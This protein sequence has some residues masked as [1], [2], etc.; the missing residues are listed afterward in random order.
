MSSFAE[1][2]LPLSYTIFEEGGNCYA[3]NGKTRAIDFRGTDAVTV[4]NSALNALTDGRTWQE[5]VTLRGNF[6]LTSPIR[7]PEYTVLDL[8]AAKL[9]LANAANCNMIQNPD[10]SVSADERTI[11]GG[12]L[13]GNKANQT[14]GHGVHLFGERIQILNMQ[15]W[16][17][18]DYAVSIHGYGTTY[19]RRIWVLDN[20]LINNEKG[21]IN[22]DYLTGAAWVER[23][24]CF[25][26]GA[27]KAT[28]FFFDF[29]GGFRICCIN[30]YLLSGARSGLR[31]RAIESVI[32]YN[33]IKN[34]DQ[35]GIIM[36]DAAKSWCIGN[37]IMDIALTGTSL[38]DG[39]YIWGTT[40]N[41]HFLY[42]TIETTGSIKYA[43]NESE[44]DWNDISHN[45]CKTGT[46]NK[47]GLN[48]I[49][50]DNLVG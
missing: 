39:I 17:C 31:C 32:A 26:Q 27:A 40:N 19:S 30:N 23:N 50:V 12:I 38:Y 29:E 36:G 4:I 7:L 48:S 10:A 34:F 33:R 13:D 45:R 37:L 15:I 18:K 42:N 14:S 5:K 41:S 49:A 11:I 6:S 24:N 2:V 3:Q 43:I 46:I 47:T 1:P 16:N 44:G 9:T 28:D 35:H 25:K 22:M 8:R 20:S 21:A